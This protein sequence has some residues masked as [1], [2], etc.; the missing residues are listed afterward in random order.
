VS[1]RPGSLFTV[2]RTTLA[3]TALARTALARY[4]LAAVLAVGAVSVTACSKDDGPDESTYVTTQAT[5]P[6]TAAP[7]TTGGPAGAT[8]TA[9]PAGTET[10]A[11][12]KKVIATITASSKQAI[13]ALTKAMQSGDKTKV[14]QGYTQVKTIYRGTA[15]ALRLQAATVKDPTLKKQIQNAA[16]YFDKAAN[17]PQ[18]TNSGQDNSLAVLSRTCSGTT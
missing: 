11:A 3:R 9:P 13:A 18:S 2:S 8:A 17:N 7:G 10:K 6:S 12:C 5:Q 15:S 1:P 14:A 4:V 16:G